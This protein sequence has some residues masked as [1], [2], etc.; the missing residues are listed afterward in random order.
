[1][2]M[3]LFIKRFLYAAVSESTGTALGFIKC[4]NLDPL[5]LL[6]TGYDHLCYTLAVI[7]DEIL[8]GQVSS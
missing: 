4:L 7:Y 6:M 8:L 1:M 3:P 2:I 5:C